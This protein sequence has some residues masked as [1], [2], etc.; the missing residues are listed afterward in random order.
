MKI[1][2]KK[3]VEK[4]DYR[5][6]GEV[7]Y[8]D[9][10]KFDIYKKIFRTAKTESELKNQLKKDNIE[11]A[12]IDEFCRTLKKLKLFNENGNLETKPLIAEYGDYIVTLL[13][14][15]EDQPPPLS[16]SSSA[17]GK[18]SARTKF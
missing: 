1:E 4:T 7:A 10:Q 16:I 11:E 17:L 6:I 5:F 14:Q 2:L 3:S 13:V 8:L 18:E 9:E 12:A 15:K